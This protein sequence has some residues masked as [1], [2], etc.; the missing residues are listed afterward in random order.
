MRV[1]MHDIVEAVAQ[2]SGDMPDD[3]RGPCRA[4]ALVRARQVA[5][6]LGRD[7]G[8]SLTRIGRALGGRDHTTVLQGLRRVALLAR[9]D[10][11]L[12]DLIDAARGAVLARTIAR[13]AGVGDVEAL[14]GAVL[15]RLQAAPVPVLARVA[16]LLAVS[17]G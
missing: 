3:L 12:A 5:Y 16:G 10:A 9:D 14:R 8:H 17:H 7:H 6:W 1:S 11:D 2:V 15:A 4:A 13:R